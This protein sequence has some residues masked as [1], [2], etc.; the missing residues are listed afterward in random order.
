MTQASSDT[1]LRPGET[2]WRIER[3]DRVALIVDAADYFIHLRQALIA[4]KETIYLIG[5]DFDLRIETVPGESD[6]E[7]NAPDGWPNELGPF[8]E[9]V[10][11]RNGGVDMHVL[12]WDG[13]MI[14][15]IA[16]QAF[17]T[18]SLKMSSDRI[19]FALDSHHPVGA[20]HHQKIVVVDDRLAFC[21]GIDVTTG[22]WD[23]REHKPDDERRINP[24][25]DIHQCWHDVTT[26]LEGP[27]AK[28]LGDLARMR[29]KAANGEELEAPDVTGTPWPERLEADLR[30]VDLGIARTAPRYHGDPLVN[31]IEE[32]YLA[33]IRG[34]KDWIYIENQYLAATTICEALEER[35]REPNGPEIVMLNPQQSQSW[36]EDR[37]MNSIRSR[38]IERLDAAAAEGGGRFTLLYPANAAGNAIYVH[39]KVMVMDGRALKIGSSN[40]D[41]RSMGF[42]TECDVALEASSDEERQAI[43]AFTLSLLAEHLGTEPETVAEVWE[44]EGSL[45]D[46]IHALNAQEGRGLRPIEALPLTA[47]EKTLADTRIFDPRTWP[48]NRPHPKDAV[49]HGAKRAASPYQFEAAGVGTVVVTAGA[50]ALAAWAGLSLWQRYR[51]SRRSDLAAPAIVTRGRYRPPVRR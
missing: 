50:V 44:R 12:K 15:E 5:W 20:C 38:M 9:A 18:I 45:T 16:Q 17:E 3:A 37:A 39:A 34:A 30:D 40:I 36:L 42:D 27:V 7:G 29:W 8:L 49:K 2:C 35:L 28:A 21:G 46:A 25:G 14:A 26:A 6:E 32:L 31:E 23:T 24:G 22:R 1:L 19:H 41:N 4:A 33:M 43:R 51:A 11:E 48:R 13:A 47:F 10:V